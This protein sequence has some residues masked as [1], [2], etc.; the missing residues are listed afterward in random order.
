MQDFWLGENRPRYR[1][2]DTLGKRSLCMAATH[3][4]TN[5]RAVATHLPCSYKTTVIHNGIE[6]AS[7]DP[8]A[9]GHPFRAQFGIPLQ[10]PV[11]GMVG[12]LRPWKGQ[13]RF[14]RTMAHVHALMPAAWFVIVGGAIF[15]VDDN[16]PQRLWALADELGLAGQVIFTG[17]LDDVRPAMAALDVF[18]HPG[19]PEPFGLVNVEAMAAGKPVVALNHGAL[20]EIVIDQETGLLVQPEDEDALVQAVVE[21]L[22][23]PARREVLGRSGRLRAEAYF[24][25]EQMTDRIEQVWHAVALERA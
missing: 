7:F 13:E 11:V 6:V 14:L 2:L 23:N 9:D 15:D 1:A 12:R 10:T 3:V 8:G 25:A 4:V 17:H 24:T 20:P 18:V 21:L 5:S 22:R 19:E 16:Y